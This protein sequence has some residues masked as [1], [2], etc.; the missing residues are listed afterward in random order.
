MV[1]KIIF[2]EVKTEK[3]PKLAAF[4]VY[5]RPLLEPPLNVPG[6]APPPTERVE[7]P[8]LG[9]VLDLGSVVLGLAAGVDGLPTLGCLPIPPGP[10]CGLCG[11]TYGEGCDVCGLWCG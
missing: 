2:E 1:E 6:L 7:G 5:Q 8:A 11:R 3:Q 9:L 10:V 4:I